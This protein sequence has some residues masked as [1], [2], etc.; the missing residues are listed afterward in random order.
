MARGRPTRLVASAY[1]GWPIQ[2]VR[3]L[4]DGLRGLYVLYDPHGRAVRVGISG[5]GNQDVK[6]RLVNY[7]SQTKWRHVHT[8]S[9]YTFSTQAHFN[10]VEVLMLRAVG[11]ALAGNVNAGTFLKTTKLHRPPRVRHAKSFV[12]RVVPDDGILRSPSLAGRR[13]RIEVGGTE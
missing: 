4:P 5:R 6:R 10:Q 9:V 1:E 13:V 11:S 2:S 7:Y 12:Q 3:Q 8:F